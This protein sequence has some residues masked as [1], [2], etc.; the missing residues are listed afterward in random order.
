VQKHLKPQY[1]MQVAVKVI[2][3]MQMG[4]TLPHGRGR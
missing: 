2:I 3:W 1:L 4:V